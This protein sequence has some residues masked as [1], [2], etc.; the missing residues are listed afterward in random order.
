MNAATDLNSALPMA[1]QTLQTHMDNI[2]NIDKA[3]G[4]AFTW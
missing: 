2:I 4:N 3:V 1:G